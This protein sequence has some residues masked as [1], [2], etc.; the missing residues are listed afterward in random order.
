MSAQ[1]VSDTM[2]DALPAQS[3]TEN[4]E[5]RRRLCGQS[6]DLGAAI[7]G[8]AAGMVTLQREKQK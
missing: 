4:S 1:A 7:G 5:L 3:P 8:M 2:S 6:V